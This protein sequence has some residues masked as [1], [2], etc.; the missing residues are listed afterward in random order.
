MKLEPFKLSVWDKDGDIMKLRMHF[1]SNQRRI[2]ANGIGAFICGDWNVA[3]V[4]FNK[5]L[6]LSQGSDGPAKYILSVME[7]YNFTVP[8]DWDGYRRLS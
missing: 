2:W 6:D 7:E 1:D 4:H 5:V 8:N 3:I